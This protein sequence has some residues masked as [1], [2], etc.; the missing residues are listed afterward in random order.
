MPDQAAVVETAKTSYGHHRPRANLPEILPAATPLSLLIDPSN[1]CNF[2][3][4]FCPTG[5]SERL[6]QVGRPLGMMSLALFDKI[7]DDLE[8]FPAP[9]KSAHLYK[10]GEPLANRHLGEMVRRLKTRQLA[11]HVEL[12]TNGALLTPERSDEL[13][14]AG[15]D[16]LR[17]SVY[18]MSDEEYRR[19][20]RKFGNFETVLNNVSYLFRRKTE[21]GLDFHLHC[22]IISIDLSAED[23]QRFIDLFG[24]VSD[25]I[26]VHPLHGDTLETGPF[27]AAPD[28][29]RMVCSE[30]F[31]K[32][33]INFNG[34]V[35]ACCADWSHSLV[36]GDVSVTP[37]IDIWNGP[38]LQRIRL[39]HLQGRRGEIP[40]CRDCS[41]ML[42]LP[43]DNNLDAAAAQ[44]LPRY[45]TLSPS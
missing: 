14:A 34:Q 36:V 19:V 22:K 39:L 23:R 29:Q 6:K 38:E 4:I 24:P 20:T 11:K 42:T 44:L 37:L 1:A 41:Y 5:D 12:T 30:P 9:L 35:S 16:G 33:A 40:A 31:I 8:R 26:F 2:R 13:L 10:D 21:L 17:V 7:I 15:L 18:A 45:Q 28:R 27:V 32:M 3:C 43:A 25:S